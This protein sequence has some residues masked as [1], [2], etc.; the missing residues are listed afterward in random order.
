[1]IDPA[2]AELAAAIRA[3]RICRDAP[4]GA[5]L[6]HEPRPIL[7]ESSSARVMIASQAPGNRAHQSGIPFD[8]PSGV[9]LREWLGVTREEFYHP[10]NF[11]IAPM[12]MCFPGYDAAGSDIP[13]RRECAPTWRKPLLSLMPQ[14]DLVLLIGQYAQN[15]HLGRRGGMSL[16]A[17]VEGWRS[18]YGRNEGARMIP[19]PHPSWR[20]T[21]WLKK[22]PWFEKE[23]LP[24][25][26]HEIRA[27][28]F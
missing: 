25:L 5:P 3:C 26:Q 15:W 16:T 18:I 7:W 21:G 17:T 28:I 22:H 11:I 14:V 1:M 8:D 4:L 27:R 20:N 10:H 13:P 24:V 19:L 6:P 9:R 12:G 2:L 23:L